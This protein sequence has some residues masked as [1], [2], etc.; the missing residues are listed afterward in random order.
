MLVV[1]GLVVGGLRLIGAGGAGS[2]T[3][4][5]SPTPAGGGDPYA[6]EAWAAANPHRADRDLTALPLLEEHACPFADERRGAGVRCATLV[7]PADRH[8]QD[9]Q[10]QPAVPGPDDVV[11][12]A[13]ATI[14][15]R[16]GDARE[17][18]IL[19]LEGGPGGASVAWFD[20]WQDLHLDVLEDRDLIL[21]DQRGTGY[22]TPSLTCPELTDAADEDRALRRCH[23]RLVA[24]GVDLAT[25]STRE[26]AADVADLRVA[27]GVETWNLFGISYG[28]RVALTVLDRHPEGVRSAVLDSVYPPEVDALLD[29]GPNGTAAFEALFA[30]CE[31]D[32]V[33]RGEVGDLEV[34]LSDAVSGLDAE[35]LRDADGQVTGD[36]LVDALFDALY[37]T[38]VIPLLP[39][40]I[41]QATTDPAEALDAL[42]GAGGAEGA[43][44]ATG[45]QAAEGAGQPGA[46]D[47][48]RRRAGVVAYEDSEGTFWSVE[49]REEAAVVDAAEVRARAGALPP[50][51]GSAML[52]AVEAVLEICEEWRSGVA[53]PDERAPVVS[54]VPTLLLAG[55]LDPITPP[56]W[57]ELAASRLE[58]STLLVLPAAG[59]GVFDVGECPLGLL[60]RFLDDPSADHAVTCAA[61]HA[62]PSFTFDLP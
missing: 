12:L 24:E 26:H 39:A 9:A 45:T 25:V 22:S 34:V 6:I 17:D 8:A 47:R 38:E 13:V 23:D 2:P 41:Q 52:A 33:C 3:S 32:A 43:D 10:D 21:L 61:D 53:G 49:C 46:A 40:L 44:A 27:L 57:A 51:T 30:A 60:R 1:A 50:P 56:W 54:D 62:T 7:V 58:R 35:P 18:P 14:P 5:T 15:A 11:E 20:H 37:D 31:V 42:Q 55:G 28:T 59:H 16:G 36:D 4:L 29:Q 19:Y 48:P